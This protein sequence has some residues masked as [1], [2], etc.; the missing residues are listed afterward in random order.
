MKQKTIK[1]YF[2][3]T[4]ALIEMLRG[5]LNYS[6]FINQSRIVISKLNY[7]ELHYY[8]IRTDSYD[9]I[10]PFLDQLKNAII[11][12]DLNDIEKAS[13]LKKTDKKLS[14][15]DCI[16]YVLAK[17]HSLPFLT[18]DEQFKNKDNVLFIK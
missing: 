7:F 16:G 3:D 6:E 1:A 2:F 4:Y 13:I 11:E 14:L 12:F 15:V 8:A 18:G 17:K 10:K 9:L 5:N